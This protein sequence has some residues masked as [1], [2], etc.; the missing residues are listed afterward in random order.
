M[1]HY[2]NK[3]PILIAIGVL[4]LLAGIGIVLLAAGSLLLGRRVRRGAGI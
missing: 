1:S 4:S 2:R 3:S